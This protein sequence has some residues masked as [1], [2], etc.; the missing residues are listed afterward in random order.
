VVAES[1]D[2]PQVLKG[3]LMTKVRHLKEATAIGQ[4][5]I[6]TDWIRAAKGGISLRQG[7]AT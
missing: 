5:A 4:I 2:M 6:S 3:E 1:H 7:H